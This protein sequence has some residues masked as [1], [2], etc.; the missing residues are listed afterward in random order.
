MVEDN[1]SAEEDGAG[2]GLDESGHDGVTATV[3]G[4]VV[5]EHGGDKGDMSDSRA[6]GL[7]V[8]EV[9]GLWESFG[10]ILPDICSITIESFLR[11]NSRMAATAAFSSRDAAA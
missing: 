6:T 11:L 5:V 2:C 4:A 7:P 3:G 9:V 8:V 1:G 10:S